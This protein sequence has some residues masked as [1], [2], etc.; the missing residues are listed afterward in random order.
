MKIFQ[1]QQLF[2]ELQ[3]FIM[4]LHSVRSIFDSVGECNAGD[5]SLLIFI[6]LKSKAALCA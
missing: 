2:M 4:V 5:A 3:K 1:V 6:L